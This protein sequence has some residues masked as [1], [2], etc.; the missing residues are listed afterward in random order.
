[1]RASWDTSYLSLPEQMYK[2]QKPIPVPKPS[3]LVLNTQLAKKLG[4]SFGSDWAEYIA[5]NKVSQGATPL[6]QAYA[7]HQFGNWNPQLGDGRAV[8]LGEVTGEFGRMD[9]QLK[10]SG[11]THWSRG[12]DGRAWLGPVL[13]EYIVSEAMHKLNIPTTRALAAAGT[14]E[15]IYREEGPLPGAVIC[16][17]A[18][19]HIRVGT[20]QYF[21]SRND[22]EALEA[23][24]NYTINRHYPKA[25]NS[26]DFLEMAVQAQADLIAKWMGVGF[27]HG[28]MNTDNCSISG[29]TID[30]GP[31][32]FMDAYSERRVF[33]SIDR[34]ARYAFANQSDIAVWNMAQL[35]TSLLQLATDKERAVEEATG[36]VHAMPAQLEADWLKRFG[37]K[38]G[39]AAATP[40]DHV[41]IE[42]LLQLMEKD[43]S[44][45]TNT[46]AALGTESARDQFLDRKAFDAW[47][48][49]WNARLTNEAGPNA[50]MAAANPVII[51]RNHRIE[52]MIHTAVT[53]DFVPFERLN[54]ALATP[55]E[56]TNTDLH[57]APS[58]AQIVP[59][60]FCGT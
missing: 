52:E 40:S 29:E 38:I 9:I 54:K 42:G 58:A 28:V 41:M 26:N 21:A 44:D 13:R 16:R 27:I 47:A 51:P 59:A 19:S 11:R 49:T 39:L 20:F 36:I 18:T 34:G 4:V 6:T 7:G 22:H 8:L 25:K 37:A 14:G 43:G 1:M 60:T 33:S 12:G 30:Y 45:F 5:G 35:A 55:F 46:F 32:A 24:L 23:L 48:V 2:K 15:S 57:R 17:T 31:C 53:G 3:P 50:I 56:A 10:G